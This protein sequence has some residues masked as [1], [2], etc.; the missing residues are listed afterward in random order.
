MGPSFECKISKFTVNFEKKKE[1]WKI[2]V[3]QFADSFYPDVSQL[4]TTN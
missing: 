3:F 2:S 1:L 4:K